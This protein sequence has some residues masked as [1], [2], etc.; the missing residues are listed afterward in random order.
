MLRRMRRA[1]LAAFLR[2]AEVRELGQGA[3][4]FREGDR[5]E[6]V[7]LILEGSVRLSRSVEGDLQV[8]IATRGPLEW[9]GELSLGPEETRSATVTTESRTRLLEI[10]RDRFLEVLRAEPGAAVELLQLTAH[11]V[12]ESDAAVVDLVR[13]RTEDLVAANVRLGKEVRRLRRDDPSSA[14]LDEFVGVSRAA[15]RARKTAAR[16]ARSLLPV[17]LVGEGGTGKA[18]LA[19]LV[20]EASSPRAGRFVAVDCSLVSLETLETE[21]FGC[22]AGVLPGV[23]A[24]KPG[25]VEQAEGGTLLLEHLDR[26]PL[27][28]QAELLRLLR[29]GELQRV[30]E[31][32]VR[33][34]EVRLIASLE[35]DPEAAARDGRLRPDLLRELAAFR[36][37]IPPL[38][39]RRGD[40]PFVTLRLSQRCADS[41]GAPL[42]RFAPPALRALS[43]GELQRNGD[44]LEAEVERLYATRPAGSTVGAGDLDPSLVGERSPRRYG[45]I[46]RAFKVQLVCDALEESGGY[47][48][49]AAERL[50]LHTSNLLRLV[51]ELGLDDRLRAGKRGRPRLPR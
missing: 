37:E 48:S 34:A 43:R 39:D 7:Y 40:V 11:R 1:R 35:G 4:L 28:L 24:S 50:G 32:R 22:A 20:H 23:R 16:A 18:L 8:R 33:R 45:E 36:I 9:L 15:D 12:R 14:G 10:S 46:L 38:R 26:V 25:L 44:D 29:A 2:D 13:K 27:A 49:R 31:G 19:R 47:A 6:T 30:G 21:L 42:L 51:H 5:A 41:L 17:L 3:V